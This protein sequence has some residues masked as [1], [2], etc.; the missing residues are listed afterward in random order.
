MF[1]EK[2]KTFARKFAALT[3]QFCQ[4]I[5]SYTHCLFVLSRISPPFLHFL[6]LGTH[7]SL[8]LF[9]SAPGSR[10]IVQPGSGYTEAK[11]QKNLERKIR[12]KGS[13]KERA[14]ER[15]ETNRPGVSGEKWLCR[16][17]G[18]EGRQ[19]VHRRRQGK[20]KDKHRQRQRITEK[21]ERAQGLERCFSSKGD[22]ARSSRQWHDAVQESARARFWRGDKR[23]VSTPRESGRD[24][25]G[26][27][28]RMER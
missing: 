9:F 17:A 13:K 25:G 11:W 27:G 15:R 12:K 28:R 22:F 23:V 16:Q 20:D 6:F 21:A 1:E 18:R 10:C 26:E 4:R 3:A 19:G 2:L 5:V 24:G 7:G 8:S 14:I